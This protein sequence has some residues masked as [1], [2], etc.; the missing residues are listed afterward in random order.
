MI[1][2]RAFSP[3]R[4]NLRLALAAAIGA[5]LVGCTA[6]LGFDKDV[7]EQGRGAV[8][9]DGGSD[10]DAPPSTVE[11]GGSSDAT[12]PPDPETEVRGLPD[13]SFGDG[14]TVSIDA[15]LPWSVANPDGVSDDCRGAVDAKERVVVTCAIHNDVWDNQGPRLETK[16][17]RMSSE[18]VLA[19]DFGTSDGGV[20]GVDLLDEYLPLVTTLANGGVVL[21]GYRD[22]E[23]LLRY[24]TGK[25]LVRWLSETGVTESSLGDAGTLAPA[26]TGA[27]DN[28]KIVSIATDGD[29]LVLAFVVVR[30]GENTLVGEYS[31]WMDVDPKTA[32]ITRVT[33][34]A[35]PAFESDFA[36]GTLRPTAERTILVGAAKGEGYQPAYVSLTAFKDT[37]IDTTFGDAGRTLVRTQPKDYALR[38]VGMQPKGADGF[39]VTATVPGRALLGGALVHVASDGRIMTEVGDGG[40]TAIP[41]APLDSAPGLEILS[42]ILDPNG[43]IVAAGQV[44]FAN[45]TSKPFVVRLTEAGEVDPTFGK[46]GWIT[47]GFGDS[48]AAKIAQLLLTPKGRL[49]AIGVKLEESGTRSI[50][51]KQF[52]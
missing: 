21:A 22:V 5:G 14:G 48:S 26:L 18:G 28:D 17:F 45:K 10:R 40:A 12:S 25:S 16:V 42:A 46:D 39:L 34:P 23:P 52:R 41:S 35:V 20:S 32:S 8:L 31:G 19:S 13:P 43:K 44:V 33:D 30:V 51:V 3:K 38:V 36:S 7:V 49:V 1:A 11:D 4:R 2:G 50:F 29:R 24:D 15:K 37:Q 6:I 9:P 27:G 47:S